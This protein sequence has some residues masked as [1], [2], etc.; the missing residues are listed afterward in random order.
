YIPLDPRPEATEITELSQL[1]SVE[2]RVSVNS[3]TVKEIKSLAIDPKTYIV[4]EIDYTNAKI[5]AS[6]IVGDEI[7]K[8]NDTI[9]SSFIHLSKLLAKEGETAV[10]V[11]RRAFI[12]AP[13]HTRVQ[14]AMT[15]LKLTVQKKYSYQVVTCKKMPYDI[16][17]TTSFGFT[18]ENVTVA[19]NIKKFV[20]AEING[21]T[22]AEK[23]F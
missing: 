2:L 16:F 6:F 1:R 13:G 14:A 12:T 5:G 22:A 18:A 9:P 23:Y 11:K 20:V 21:N 8:V 4:G 19:K 10:V 3:L 7:V 17:L 15:A